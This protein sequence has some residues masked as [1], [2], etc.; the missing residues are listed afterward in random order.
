MKDIEARAIMFRLADAY[1]KLADR[2]E[3]RSKVT[4]SA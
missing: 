3:A 2:A 1:D 4:K